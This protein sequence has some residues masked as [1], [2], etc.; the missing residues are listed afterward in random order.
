MNVNFR[1]WVIIMARKLGKDEAWVI[2][3]GQTE[4]RIYE[5]NI[6]TGEIDRNAEARRKM[7]QF[8]T[9][10]ELSEYMND[11]ITE[12][13]VGICAAGVLFPDLTIQAPEVRFRE[14]VTY[15]K[16]LK[17]RGCEVI[18]ANDVEGAAYYEGTFGV[19]KGMRSATGTFSSGH[20][21][22]YFIP[23]IGVVTVA[24]FGHKKIAD[25]LSGLPCGCGNNGCVEP[26]VSGT[27]AALLAIEELLAREQRDNPII[28][29][30]LKDYN[31]AAVKE[32]LQQ[33][34]PGDLKNRRVYR[35]VVSQI[36]ASHIYSVDGGAVSARVREIQAG[37]IAQVFG[38]VTSVYR[39]LER[40]VCMGSLATKN[41]DTLMADAIGLYKTRQFH[42]PSIE[43]V[44][45]VK[46]DEE[47]NG[48]MGAGA[49]FKYKRL[50]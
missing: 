46:T 43:P 4:L 37:A 29:A 39:P 34:E 45:V 49:M 2:D 24:E 50:Q 31:E 15:P 38:A 26:Y 44:Q 13:R 19:A 36:D 11:T 1:G 17:E 33:F 35:M 6:E 40:I 8:S 7:E 25:K 12:G 30:A 27:G 22:D 18:V 47:L 28:L 21:F 41:W 14:R 5:M 3:G 42:N 16:E 20:N 48:C 10:N 9:N 23:G 32:G